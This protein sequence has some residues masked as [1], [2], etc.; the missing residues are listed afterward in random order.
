M[1][2]Y[3]RPG[4]CLFSTYTLTSKMHS[5]VAFFFSEAR[6][7][8][9]FGGSTMSCVGFN[10]RRPPAPVG[11]N[12]KYD[13]PVGKYRNITLP[14][15]KPCFI[16]Y[17]FCTASM[18]TYC[19]EQLQSTC[20]VCT[21]TTGGQPFPRE[22][23][24]LQITMFERVH[25]VDVVPFIDTICDDH[26]SRPRARLADLKTIRTIAVHPALRDSARTTPP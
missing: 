7:A 15:E 13:P 20:L 23:R 9:H 21:N 11:I 19:I 3:I 5:G 2:P 18:S 16:S 10:Y 12:S 8:L 1:H 14:L 17:G 22:L 24:I 4:D 6:N 25:W 26:P